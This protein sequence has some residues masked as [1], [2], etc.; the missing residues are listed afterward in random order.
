MSSTNSDTKTAA[1]ANAKRPVDDKLGALNS[2]QQGTGS[3]RQQPATVRF[4]DRLETAETF[5]D[6]VT[7]RVREP[8]LVPANVIGG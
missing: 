2:S 8:A 7:A 3:A 6:C 4:V 5:A 1:P